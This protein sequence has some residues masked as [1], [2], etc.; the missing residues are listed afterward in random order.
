MADGR[1]AIVAITRGGAR[2]AARLYAQLPGSD[3][4]VAEQ[5]AGE[6]RAEGAGGAVRPFVD[7]V[8]VLL[9]ALFRDYRR[10]VLFLAL[11]GV[12]RLLAPHLKDK[13]TDPGV[14]VVDEGGRFAIPVLSGHV[15]G[16]NDLARWVAAALGAQAVIT[17]AADAVDTLAVDL[18]G[19]EF[20]WTVEPGSPLTMASAAVVNGEPVGLYQDAGETG[21]WPADHPLPG[22]IRVFDDLIDLAASDCRACLVITDRAIPSGDALLRRAVIYRPK[23]LVVGIGCRR[24]ATADAI[25]EAVHRVLLSHGLSISSVRN[26]ATAEAKRDEPGLRAC[27]GHLGVPVEFFPTEALSAVAAPNPS[28]AAL[29]VLG[30]PGVCEPAA[31]LSAGARELVVEKQKAGDVTVAVARIGNT[32]RR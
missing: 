17:T 2:M 14:V 31:L 24:G 29:R 32:W 15:G 27:A 10:L 23:S 12:V 13:K 20:D 3:L 11:G 22:N 5:W 26:L 4:Y 19:R 1:V 9:P 18:L 30:T 8:G 16:A 21:W 28:A 7:P 25:E 6:A